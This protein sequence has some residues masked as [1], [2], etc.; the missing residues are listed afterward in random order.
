MMIKKIDKKTLNCNYNKINF[1]FIYFKKVNQWKLL[2]YFS[3]EGLIDNI[4]E[5]EKMSKS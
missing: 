5:Y 3:K 4:E 2:F 1:Q